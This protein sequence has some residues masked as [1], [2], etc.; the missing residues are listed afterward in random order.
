MSKYGNDSGPRSPAGGRALAL[1][2]SQQ[3]DLAVA[4]LTIVVFLVFQ[5]VLLLGPHPFDPTTYWA[6]AQDFPHIAATRWTL[7]LGV[8]VPVAIATRL[9][10]AT[11]AALYAVPLS[12][13]VL[14]VTAVYGT[15]L[16]LFRDR[17][18]AAAAALVTV[19]NANFLLNSGFIF[20]DNFAAATFA[21]GFLFLVLGGLAAQRSSPW[22]ARISIVC[23]GVFFG[24]TYLI[25]EFSPILI[26]TVVAAALLLRYPLRRIGLL[27]G[28]AVAT[29]ALELV[30]G[31]MSSG[32]PFIHLQVLLRHSDHEF[33]RR[34]Q[35]VAIV[36]RETEDPLGALRVLPR[37]VLSWDSGWL[38]LLLVPLFV[39]ALVL[40][41]DRRLG[42]LAVWCFGFWAAMVLLAMG[43][44]PSGKWIINV[45]NIRYWYPL[46]PALAMGGLAG[47]WLLVRRFAPPRRALLAAQLAVVSLA[48]LILLPGMAEF[49]SCASKNIWR[50]DPMSR[51][52]ELR[53]WLGSSEASSYRQIVTD[54]G[55]ENLFDP[56]YLSAPFGGRVWDG[57]VNTWPKSGRRLEPAKSAE[58]SLIL[59]NRGRVS[60]LRGGQESVQSLLSTWAPVF[61][62]QDGELVVLARRPVQSAGLPAPWWERSENE[63]AVTPSECGINPITGMP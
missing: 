62:S 53:S 38:F 44:L 6:A 11:E 7:R 15:M 23:A 1:T 63:P 45:S 56:V 60:M 28:A 46:F 10:G 25:R 8:V 50:N 34:E 58:N 9:M 21:S 57:D 2:R 31:A 19:L 4:G 29:G 33:S 13:G 18:L 39:V 17:V 42:I 51:W 3:L 61:V 30:F 55:T 32:S 27:A 20:P 37:L 12:A 14:L 40:L 47:L 49:R 48:A 16:A 24:W 54:R 43:H 36:Q 35:T 26:P 59:L 41:R 5:L 52:H 22:A